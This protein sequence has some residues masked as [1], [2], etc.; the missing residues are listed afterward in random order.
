MA[1]T[2]WLV[3]L[4]AGAVWL[5]LAC[6]AWA[7]ETKYY[8]SP[9]GDDAWPGTEAKPFSTIQR[10]QKAVRAKVK[11]G[12]DGKVDVIL[13]GGTY[14]LTEP[15]V[16]GPGDGGFMKCPVSYSGARGEG[17][18]ISGGVE[19]AGWRDAGDGV[20]A[21]KVPASLAKAGFNELF[22]GD[23]RAVPA[24]HPNEGYLRVV[25]AVDPRR[26]FLYRAGDIPKLG[27]PKQMT[28]VYLHDWA[29]TRVAVESIDPKARKLTTKYDVG[30]KANYWRI[31]G[32]EP[33]PRY[34]LEGAREFL[35]APG[36]WWLDGKAGQVLYRPMG[37]EKLDGFKAVAPLAKQLLVVRGRT[38]NDPVRELWF[39]DLTFEHCAWRPEGF[40]YAGSQA[41]F[42]YTGKSH[43]D[44]HR[45][46]MAPAV[47]VEN[48]RDVGLHHC[49]IRHL[50]GVGIWFGR[51]SRDCSVF[52]SILSDIAGTGVMMGEPSPQAAAGSGAGGNAIGFS[53]VEKCGQVYFGAVAIWVGLSADNHIG[54]NVIRYMPYTGVSVGWM[55]NPTPTPCKGNLVSRNH[56]HHVMQVLS[57]G[58]GIYTLGRQPGTKLVGNWIHDVP[59]NLGRAESNGMF[60]D[61]GSTELLIE[62]NL[63]HDIAKSPLRFHKAGKNL[64]KNNI[65][66]HPA[67]VPTVRYNATPVANIMLEGNRTPERLPAGRSELA[68]R[69]SAV[70]RLS[71]PLNQVPGPQD[72]TP[73]VVPPVL[74][75]P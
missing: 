41:G 16:F 52:A 62:N 61:E 28:L 10:A 65:L 57:D 4:A 3:L 37:G 8:V 32:Y 43:Q 59:V 12:L 42:H 70:R 7:E 39:S 73:V 68:G 33:H 34:F 56:I 11:A 6:G 72:A 63:I 49:T 67:K 36:E 69:A 9:K 54:N 27:D 71:G 5:G 25:K 21:A 66:V 20:W 45:G 26:S 35:D 44:G 38:L 74:P 2:R 14:R 24:R 19:I 18:V 23:R 40:R 46:A 64:V 22:V 55:W 31:C 60:L 50:G 51:G 48:A 17:A 58:G 15:L 47:D 1:K 29:I 53:R 75:T 30:C 13:R